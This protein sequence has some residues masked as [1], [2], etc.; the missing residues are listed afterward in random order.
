MH[1][2]IGGSCHSPHV[3]SGIR[4]QP[5]LTPLI[6]SDAHVGPGHLAN[7]MVAI[8]H[9]IKQTLTAHKLI[10]CCLHQH[11]YIQYWVSLYPFSLSFCF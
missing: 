8:I 5:Q 11:N 3:C 6:I 2:E 4:L 10:V 9:S 1:H 7:K